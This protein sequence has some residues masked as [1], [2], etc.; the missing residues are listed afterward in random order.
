MQL[1]LFC[2]EETVRGHEQRVTAHAERERTA[3][4]LNAR[5]C[6]HR[7]SQQTSGAISRA[8]RV[9]AVV[10]RANLSWCSVMPR[11]W[12]PCLVLS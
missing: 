3:R 6:A 10:Q 7:G 8:S 11:R 1:E 9:E 2:A 5:R 12:N 4:L